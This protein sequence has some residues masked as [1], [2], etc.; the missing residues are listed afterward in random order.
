MK[1]SFSK[2]ST[3]NTIK[4]LIAMQYSPHIAQSEL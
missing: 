3:L 1:I 4:E 2:N